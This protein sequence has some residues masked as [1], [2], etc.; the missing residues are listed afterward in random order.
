MRSDNQSPSTFDS[1]ADGQPAGSQPRETAAAGD[2]SVPLAAERLTADVR[3][4]ARG[5]VHIRKRVIHEPRRAVVPLTIEEALIEHI[6]P[7][8]FD[9]DAPR[10]EGEL[11]IPLFEE[12]LVVRKETVVR[13]YLRVRKR[14]SVRRGEVRGE[15]RREVAEIDETPDPAYGD[16]PGPLVRESR[17]DQPSGEQA[18]R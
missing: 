11:I 4:G 10:A 3:Q 8:R 1:S 15:V 12:R 7:D 17:M 16:Q 14:S 18:E 5:H 9:P 2:I 13:E 6:P